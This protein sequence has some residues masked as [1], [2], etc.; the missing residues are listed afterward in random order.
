MPTLFSKLPILKSTLMNMKSLFKLLYSRVD[1]L[2]ITKVSSSHLFPLR[3]AQMGWKYICVLQMPRV[4][5]Y[6]LCC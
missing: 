5:Q 1:I 4:I 3:A 2:F 6:L